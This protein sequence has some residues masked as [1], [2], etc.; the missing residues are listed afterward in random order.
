M[1]KQKINLVDVLCDFNRCDPL[2]LHALI[3]ENYDNNKNFVKTLTLYTNH[4]KNN[5]ALKANF[6]S[7][8]GANQLFSHRGYKGKI[9][10][11]K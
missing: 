4:L 3:R 1:I 11:R 8:V 7:H 2:E 9:G 6:I 10:Y 5:I